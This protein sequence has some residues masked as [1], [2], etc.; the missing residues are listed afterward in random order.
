VIR[1]AH[2]DDMPA[3]MEMG[4]A[5]FAEA[6]HEGSFPGFEFD[7][8]S[9]EMTLSLLGQSNLLLVADKG[10]GAVGMGAIDVATAYWNRKVVLSREAFWYVQPAH[11][12]GLGRALLA[13]METAAR[14]YGAV[15]FDV[16]AEPGPRS[17]TLEILYQRKGF[18]PAERTFRKGL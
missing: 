16:V 8:D 12:K 17:E 14:S 4:R 9:F 11:R 2:P 18:N 1:A 5:F 6:G 15:V 13:A 10:Q 7:P 3:L